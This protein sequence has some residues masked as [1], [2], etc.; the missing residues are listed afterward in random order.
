MQDYQELTTRLKGKRVNIRTYWTSS[1]G[2][3]IYHGEL[4][5][6]NWERGQV[7]LFMGLEGSDPKTFETARRIFGSVEFPLPDPERPPGR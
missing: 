5:V 1:E 4:N 2:R 3:R 7:T 6:G